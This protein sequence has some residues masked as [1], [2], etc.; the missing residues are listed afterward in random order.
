MATLLRFA[1]MTLGMRE[2]EPL[3]RAET[4]SLTGVMSEPVH[5]RTL[6]LPPSTPC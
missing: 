6:V 3:A 2:V 5:C 4:A 1:A